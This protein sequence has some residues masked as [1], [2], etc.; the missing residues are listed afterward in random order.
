[1]PEF[2]DKN[3][4]PA[5]TVFVDSKSFNYCW[6]YLIGGLAVGLLIG[7]LLTYLSFSNKTVDQGRS[8]GTPPPEMMAGGMPAAADRLNDSSENTIVV[9]MAEAID[10]TNLQTINLNNLAGNLEIIAGGTYVLSGTLNNSVV[11]NAPGETVALKLVGAT[12]NSSNQAA[13]LGLSQEKLIIV[14][15]PGTQNIVS[16]GGSSEYD[17]AIFSNSDLVIQ[18]AGELIVNGIVEE[19]IATENANLTI[20]DGLITITALDD[21]IN[22]GG[23]GGVIAINGGEIYVDAQGDGID[24]N[25][26]LIINGGTIFV[27]GS[28]SADNAGLDADGIFQINGGI[29]VALGAGMLET[30]DAN[31]RQNAL[32]LNLDNSMSA[33][34]DLAL[35]T[36][37][38]DKI[39]AF[40][41]EKPFR[42]LTI[43]T[44]SLLEGMYILYQG[45]TNSG[46]LTGGTYQPGTIVSVGGTSEL[47]VTQAV[48]TYGAAARMGGGR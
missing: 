9:A 35:T 28:T 27:M 24:S 12:I 14:L 41:A 21:G 32:F 44:P 6:F 13:I 36:V 8:P 46:G 45:G 4:E 7:W 33:G 29:L 1:M 18:G 37:E 22:A 17:A 48:N 47:A 10:E 34:T 43:S 25:K 11:I 38:G 26:D 39:V 40:M 2:T 5:P 42:T 20:H 3:L 19:G 15:Q 23:D 31:S 16:D 30:S